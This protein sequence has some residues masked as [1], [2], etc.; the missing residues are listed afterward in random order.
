MQ[1]RYYK[2]SLQFKQASGTS[3]GILTTKDSWFIEL[4]EGGAKGL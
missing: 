4:Q 1:A 3:R 2:H